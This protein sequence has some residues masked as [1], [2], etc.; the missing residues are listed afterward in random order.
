MGGAHVYQLA[1]HGSDVPSPALARR[2]QAAAGIV[3][4]LPHSAE[5]MPGGLDSL[6]RVGPKLS[7]AAVEAWVWCPS[8][9]DLLA[10]LPE[11]PATYWFADQAGDATSPFVT[12]VGQE[13]L[14]RLSVAARPA[15]GDD[16]QEGAA[17]LDG[18]WQRIVQLGLLDERAGPLQPRP[19]RSLVPLDR[20][21]APARL[22]GLWRAGQ[23]VQGFFYYQ[24]DAEGIAACR[25]LAQVGR[26]TTTVTLER[27]AEDD[28]DLL[29]AE[30]GTDM[31]LL[32]WQYDRVDVAGGYNYIMLVRNTGDRNFS[33]HLPGHRALLLSV[34]WKT[35]EREAAAARIAA[36][37]G[38]TLGPVVGEL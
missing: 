20:A 9:P 16:P 12:L 18:W 13:G 7:N 15:P 21:E 38:A 19:Q 27:A 10:A 3:A 26:V 29:W 11:L 28:L 33:A 14:S 37:I 2:L 23:P 6:A 25:R 17:R 8:A 4:G 32:R 22:A 34:N 36:M 24:A 30:A 31:L 1:L 5:W 35:P